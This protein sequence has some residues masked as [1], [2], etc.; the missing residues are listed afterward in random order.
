MTPMSKPALW[1]TSTSSPANSR[2]AGEVVGPAG[3]VRHHLGRDAVDADVPLR[4]LVVRERRADVASA[5][6]RRPG[7]RAPSRARPSRPTRSSEL[8]VSKS[9]AVKSTGTRASSHAA[10]DT[11]GAPP[12]ASAIG[13][14]TVDGCRGQGVE[15]LRGAA[16]CD[17]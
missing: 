14:G 10:S 5:R 6:D 9:I 8:A 11:A 12:G 15:W 16:T 7:R 17:A 13:A 3:G 1:A 4:E 2:S